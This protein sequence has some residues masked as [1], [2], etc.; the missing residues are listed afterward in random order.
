MA[1]EKYDGAKKP[2]KTAMKIK[3]KATRS[4]MERTENE[5]KAAAHI[6]DRH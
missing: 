3:M 5:T 2:R 6:Q 1:T 4:W